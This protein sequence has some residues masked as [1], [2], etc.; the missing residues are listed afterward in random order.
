MRR[1]LNVGVRA[2]NWCV[3]VIVGLLAA[4]VVGGCAQQTA[5]TGR[6]VALEQ[7]Y[8][9]L[10][11]QYKQ[12]QLKLIERER[13]LAAA[14]G[15]VGIAPDAPRLDGAG[16]G[17]G[18]SRPVPSEAAGGAGAE[19]PFA[20][21]SL[22]FG[23]GTEAVDRTGDG[24]AD[25][26]RVLLEPRDRQD[27]TVKRTGHLELS[28]LDLSGAEPRVVLRRQFTPDQLA[29]E[30]AGGLLGSG[31]FVELAWP[32]E[33]RPSGNEVTVR[34]RLMT[35]EG[36]ELSAQRAVSLELRSAAGRE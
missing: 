36:R 31:F 15:G 20:A 19:D 2:W 6:P 5:R 1:G 28:V 4:T 10:M 30:W 16:D 22:R 34:A 3:A 12:L 27:G 8:E 18:E 7:R 25:G 11:V 9:T 24:R 13:Q 29:L 23:R 35:L 17:A 32:Q 21:V 26:V 14:T 33:S